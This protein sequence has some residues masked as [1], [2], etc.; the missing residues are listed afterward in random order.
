[1]SKRELRIFKLVMVLM[2]AVALGLIVGL[3]TDPYGER[4]VSR[5]A[6]KRPLDACLKD[7][8]RLKAL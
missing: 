2:V 8:E 7:A 1:M 3:I 6:Q 5:C 4:W